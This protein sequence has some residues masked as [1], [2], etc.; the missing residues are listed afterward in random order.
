MA[1]IK[2]TVNGLSAIPWSNFAPDCTIRKGPSTS[3]AQLYWLALNQNTEFADRSPPLVLQG[4]QVSETQGYCETPA[5]GGPVFD[6]YM[7]WRGVFGQD[8]RNALVAVIYARASDGDTDGYV[9]FQSEE[10]VDYRYVT[11]SGTAWTRYVISPFPVNGSISGG[12]SVAG[13]DTI[14]CRMWRKSGPG[15]IQLRSVMLYMDQ[16]SSPLASGIEESGFV[17]HDLFEVGADMP[18]PVILTRRMRENC[19][20]LVG[21]RG[22]LRPF[23]GECVP[24]QTGGSP[25]TG[26][27][28]GRSNDLAVWRPVGPPLMWPRQHK[29]F[30]LRYNILAEIL[31]YGDAKLRLTNPFAGDVVE[32]EIPYQPDPTVQSDWI[33]GEL[34]VCGLPLG[35]HPEADY[36]DRILVEIISYGETDAWIQGMTI[37]EVAD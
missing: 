10:I 5:D 22:W 35:W 4:C 34:D 19:L 9:L 30:A 11:V 28:T 37:Q 24:L 16:H 25:V 17:A 31:M 32:H 12:G 27:A 2:D 18:Y 15:R 14:T 8:S 26:K 3:D 20:S 1:R 7:A 21:G 13:W 6:L 29:K 33:M 36:H 23:I